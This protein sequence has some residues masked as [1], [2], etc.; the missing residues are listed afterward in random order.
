[1]NK[2]HKYFSFIAA[3]LLASGAYAQSIDLEAGW[4]LVGSSVDNVKS[5][6]F[7]SV[8]TV[9]GYD[10]QSKKWKVYSPNSAIED[11]I[12][13]L[14]NSGA[15]SIFDT[16][17][18]GDGFWIN[19][20]K[21][22][23][24]TLD[25][26]VSSKT[27]KVL[28]AGWNL[29]SFSGNNP[30]DIS[31]VFKDNG[32]ILT[33]WTYDNGWK[34]WSPSS[35]INNLIKNKLGSENVLSVIRPNVGYWVNTQMATNISIDLT[36]PPATSKNII[37]IYQSG[38]SGNIIPISG[39][40]LLVDGKVIGKTNSAGEFDFSRLGLS[41][42]TVVTVEKDGF[43][44]TT[45][46][47]QNG[48]LTLSIAPLQIDNSAT[49]PQTQSLTRKLMKNQG[50]VFIKQ[51]SEG[52][53]IPLPTIVTISV[54]GGTA[55]FS[56]S[57][58]V[59]SVTTFL[60]MYNTPSELPGI[61]N[62]IV[63]PNL[64][65]PV[66]PKELSIIG[67]A[68][69][70]LRKPDG[71]LVTDLTQYNNTGLSYNV[72][73]DR[74]IGDFGKIL[75]GLTGSTINH[76]NNF[77][78]DV[79][80]ALE[81]AKAKGLINFYLILQQ[82][83]GTWKYID[84]AKFVKT[85]TGYVMRPV[86]VDKISE[87]GAGNIAYVI[88]TKAI[89]GTTKVCLKY[90]GERMF[91]GKI[92]EN[93]LTGKPVVG[94]TIVPDEHVI[95]QPA[96]TGDDG[97]SMVN[98]KVPFLAPMY[99]LTAVKDGMYNE[100]ITVEIE[101]GHLDNNV[102]EQA[103]A[104][105][106][107]VSIKGY[108]KSTLNNVEKAESN[109]IVSLRDPQI[110]TAD[111]IKI[112]SQED[113]NSIELVS[114]PNIDYK[115]IIHK[116][117]SNKSV[118]I[119]DGNASD[120]N[121]ILTEKDIENVIYN[122]DENK[123]PWIDNPYGHYYIDVIATHH[124][125]QGSQADFT[126]AMT[127]E[128]DAQVDEPALVNAFS[129]SVNQGDAAVYRVDENGTVTM[130]DDINTSG[131]YPTS[132]ELGDIKVPIT[133][134]F[135][136]KDLG[137]FEPIMR[138]ANPT[139]DVYS[140]GF[141]A[142]DSYKWI[143]DVM[144]LESNSSD[145]CIDM[146]D[147]DDAQNPYYKNLIKTYAA[148]GYCIAKITPKTTFD[149][150]ILPFSQ[151][152][153][154]FIDNYKDIVKPDP[155]YSN[156][157]Y[158]ESG[159]TV[160]N[161]YK[162]NFDRKAK[163]GYVYKT[164]VASYTSLPSE[165]FTKV[166]DFSNVINFDAKTNEALAFDTRVKK[167]APDG[168]YRI[169]HIPPA[170]IPNLELMARAEGTKYNTKNFRK[171]NFPDGVYS[172]NLE[173]NVSG[174][175]DTFTSYNGQTA[176]TPHAGD[177]LVHNFMLDR[178][179]PKTLIMGFENN[180]T[181]NLGNTWEVKK[182]DVSNAYINTAISESVKWNIVNNASLPKVNQN[183]IEDTFNGSADAPKTILSTPFGNS[184][185]WMGDINTGTYSDSGDWNSN[186]QVATALVSPVIDFSDYS[187]ATLQ[188]KTWFEVSAIDAAWDTAFI[189][190]EIVD[191][192]ATEQTSEVPLVYYNGFTW[193]VKL[194]QLYIHKLT[195]TAPIVS[196]YQASLFSNNG[197]NA[198]PSW[199][200]Y[201]IPLDFLAGHKARIVFG[202]FTA[203]NLFNNFRGWGVDNIELKDNV[204]YV[205]QTPPMPQEFEEGVTPSEGNVTTIDQNATVA[206]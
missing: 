69:I 54:D 95:S 180:L 29:I 122:S 199:T 167:T 135:G 129:K 10:S 101:Y 90:D 21:K 143:T 181:D 34:A 96:A 37:F 179:P 6:S 45:G 72:V 73:L 121:N 36:P 7:N 41:D 161:T 86:N 88:R 152:Y 97:C 42:G 18:K 58:S 144:T 147:S 188:L 53:E 65:A 156:K 116:D 60:T 174:E 94:A 126:E 185:A 74:F 204:D 146:S 103:L 160:V 71:S 201:K 107:D 157:P 203:D 66:T 145:N 33:V 195:P 81:D 194:N 23:T 134:V 59:S 9:W 164:Y 25:G 114:E 202:F 142:P 191:D 26:D 4:N 1:M 106:N 170:V 48:A 150:Q 22:Q 56:G 52:N 102:T 75:E 159:F 67:G 187:L 14:E 38:S 39:A 62:N 154:M 100:P 197:V 140:S 176:Y 200:D 110:L 61:T 47:V 138:P 112:N 162:A 2:K 98:Y 169:D 46:I 141:I 28:N 32:Q 171:A 190:F 3:T 99:H 104:K 123:N 17:N 178:L 193:T 91:D 40:T 149:K 175:S 120:G 172:G 137:W 173:S 177:V 55:E 93:E 108:V 189:G 155:G 8:T 109:A 151:V 117:D 124:Y 92:V 196:S 51:A 85:S 50:S 24:I 44:T 133:S 163:N 198:L 80:K 78:E 128:F 82:K 192:N 70:T 84:E 30:Q 79:V 11:K 132:K 115:W 76:S 139:G 183:Y 113:N 206:D 57:S 165:K 136:G 125:A 19:S 111:K 153:K 105:P 148:Q 12:K 49:P 184:Y 13:E 205:I 68:N 77:N 16:L 131:Q 127:I 87:F 168:S 5:S 182:L 15:F 43:T 64:S 27:S 119:K 83:D 158:Y 130:V 63:V 31:E 89:T 20:A 186:H 118:T 166:S 35:Y